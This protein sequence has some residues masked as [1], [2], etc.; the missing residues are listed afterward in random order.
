MHSIARVCSS[1]A[2]SALLLALASGC[3][4]NATSSYSSEV[5]AA[6]ARADMT[7]DMV[8]ADLK[9]GNARFVNGNLTKR[10]WLKQAEKTAGG[11]APKAIVLS[12][13][14]SRVIPEIVFDQGIG[15]IFV[16]RVAGNFENVDKLGSM[17]FGTAVAGSKLIVVLGHTKCGAV[18]GT[19]DRA[20]LG[21][22]TATLENIRPA[23][24]AAGDLGEMSSSNQRLLD[25][26]TENNV[27]MTMND[28]KS[29]SPVLTDLINQGKLKI[30]GGI[31]DLATGRVTWLES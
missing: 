11:Q 14:D 27:R 24:T 8:Y 13:L 2:V 25:A 12:C 15:D 3:A 4:G 18:M 23:V 1:T 6:E 20:E 9:A 30:V 16:G 26:V 28:I 29:R 17:E 21:N 10:D 5:L 19:I 22:L 7:P 31:Y